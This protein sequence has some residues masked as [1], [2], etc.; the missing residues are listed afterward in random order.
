MAK[1][2][3]DKDLVREL[4]ILLEENGLMEIEWSEG[5]RTVRIV[6][7][8]P[9]IAAAPTRDSTYAATPLLQRAAEP[10]PAIASGNAEN[11]VEGTHPGAVTSPV[12]GTVYV[13]PEPG[14]APFVTVGSQVRQGQTLLIVEAMKTMNPIPAPRSGKVTRVL[15]NDAVPVEFGQALVIIE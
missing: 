6:R 5:G 12:V 3:I 15:V 2:K 8:P 13:A 10:T 7:N 4:S 14:A 1:E 9:T 11:T